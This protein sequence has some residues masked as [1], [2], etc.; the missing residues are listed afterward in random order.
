MC[1]PLAL[2]FEE[3]FGLESK[4]KVRRTRFYQK[5]RQYKILT[6]IFGRKRAQKLVK[7]AISKN[8]L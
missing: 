4:Q 3:F 8:E 6:E 2:Q 1:D 5:M 7:K